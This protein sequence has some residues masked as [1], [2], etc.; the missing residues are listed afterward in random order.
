[1]HRIIMLLKNEKQVKCNERALK[2]DTN[3]YVLTNKHASS[4]ARAK[5]LLVKDI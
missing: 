2:I 3:C 5:I 4:K 1:M